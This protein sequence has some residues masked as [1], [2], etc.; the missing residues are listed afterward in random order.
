MIGQTPPMGWNSWPMFGEDV[1]E[2]VIMQV[3]DAFVEY[4]LKDAGYEYIVIDDCWSLRERDKNKRLVPDPQKFPS[5]MKALSDYVHSKGLKLG[6]YSCAGVQT[7]AGYP[8]S[9]EHEFI[10]ANTFAEW[11]IDYLKYVYCYKP[12][13][14]DGKILYRRMAMALRNCGRDIL[15]STC[16][17]GWDEPSTWMRSAGAHTWRSTGDIQDNWNSVK[18][19][20]LSLLGHECYSAPY[21]FHDND[22]LVVGMYGKGNIALGGCTDDEYKTQ[23][24][25]WCM[26]NSPLM[27]G[28]DVRN[29]NEAT[30]TILMNKDLIAINQDF[31][32]RQAYTVNDWISDDLLYY[33]KILSN[34]DFAIALVNFGER[35]ARAHFQFWD[36]GLPMAAGYGLQLTDLWTKEDLGVETAFYRTMLDPHCCQVLRAK[37]VKL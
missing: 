20:T 18:S 13:S 32:G 21:C 1:N 28:C 5:G 27:I 33:V 16:N 24:S 12:R 37:V 19:I 31:E 30:R 23:F 11:G 6:I 35:R 9:L 34:G 8:G 3:A 15:L 4:G 36:L 14:L 17:W 26:M 10:D 2:E 22:Y 25:L 29:M 7:C